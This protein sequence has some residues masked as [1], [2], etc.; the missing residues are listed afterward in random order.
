MCKL[1]VGNLKLPESFQFGK[2][3]IDK[4]LQAFPGKIVECKKKRFVISKLTWVGK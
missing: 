3:K 1:S 2:S 4:N